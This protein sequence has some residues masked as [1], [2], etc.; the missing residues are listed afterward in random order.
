MSGGFCAVPFHKRRVWVVELVAGIAT[1]AT[2]LS[3][4]SRDPQRAYF[5]PLNDKR[6]I[7]VLNDTAG[8]IPAYEFALF[9]LS[10]DQATSLIRQFNEEG[11]AQITESQQSILIAGP[12][13]TARTIYRS[14]LENTK[15]GALDLVTP[16]SRARID[17]CTLSLVSGSNYK[18]V[19]R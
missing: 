5:A 19:A 15:P 3:E 2:K 13:I 16:F 17:P 10:Q 12:E 18:A 8:D 1:L 6:A 9:V 11:E 7:L 4:D 14:L